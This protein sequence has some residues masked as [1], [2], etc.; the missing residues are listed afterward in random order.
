MILDKT[1]TRECKKC[2]RLLPSD[3]FRLNRG[4]FEYTCRECQNI[5][6][7]LRKREIVKNNA[8]EKI[9]ICPEK[10]KNGTGEPKPLSVDKGEMEKINICPEKHKNGTGEPKPLSV[11]K[12]EMSAKRGSCPI[13]ISPFTYEE[14]LRKQ[15]WY[16]E[17]KIY[18]TKKRRVEPVSVL[19]RRLVDNSTC[20]KVYN[21]KTF[22]I[23]RSKYATVSKK[24]SYETHQILKKKHAELNITYNEIVWRLIENDKT[25]K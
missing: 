12:G 14:L 25:T 10:H 17:P 3:S 1:R 22:Q 24:V 8:D 15:I 11:D 6:D 18:G 9:N 5:R 16:D 20:E 4:Y 2:H 19:I 21:Y 23:K 7:K 13:N